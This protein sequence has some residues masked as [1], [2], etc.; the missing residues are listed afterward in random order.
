VSGTPAGML[1]VN[2]ATGAIW[3]H[4]WHGGFLAQRG[5]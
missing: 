1:S 2:Q 3:Y 5:Y 4:G